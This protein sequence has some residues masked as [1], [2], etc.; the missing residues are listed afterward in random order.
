MTSAAECHISTK[1]ITSLSVFEG[2]FACV[3]VR[4]ETFKHV[5]NVQLN[6]LTEKQNVS[7]NSAK[8]LKDMYMFDETFQNSLQAFIPQTALARE[9]FLLCF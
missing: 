9:G 3:A 7:Y 6:A 8:H 1:T 2:T 5:F 4:V